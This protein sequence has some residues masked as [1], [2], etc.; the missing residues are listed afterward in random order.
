[1][2]VNIITSR[3]SCHLIARISLLCW[4]SLSPGFI[5]FVNI[6][7]SFLV[8]R[9]VPQLPVLFSC[10]IL[11]RVGLVYQ[12]STKTLWP[13][14]RYGFNNVITTDLEIPTRSQFSMFV[15]RPVCTRKSI[16]NPVQQSHSTKSLIS[17]W[18]RLEDMY[19]WN[20]SLAFQTNMLS[21]IHK[22]W[23]GLNTFWKLNFTLSMML[24]ILNR[25]SSS[26]GALLSQ[27]CSTRSSSKNVLVWREF[28]KR[29]PNNW[30]RGPVCLQCL[31][32]D[33]FH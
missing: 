18:W 22:Y 19:C 32:Q 21:S 27:K 5:F 30:I 1:M 29:G 3:L 6:G 10:S 8:A 16:I 14:L 31:L 12:L 24:Q 2:V 13:F 23:K 33:S 11:N 25:L 9:T 4:L 20:C 28:E 26:V 15:L 7:I 17:K